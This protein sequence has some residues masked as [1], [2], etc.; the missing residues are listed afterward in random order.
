MELGSRARQRFEQAPRPHSGTSVW[1]AGGRGAGGEGPCHGTKRGLGPQNSSSRSLSLAVTAC[2]QTQLLGDCL[3]DAPTARE[4]AQDSCCWGRLGG[5][6]RPFPEAYVRSGE[7]SGAVLLVSLVWAGGMGRISRRTV[8][9]F[10]RN[11]VENMVTVIKSEHLGSTYCMP[12]TVPGA[13]SVRTQCILKTA[14]GNPVVLIQRQDS[15]SRRCSSVTPSVQLGRRGVGAARDPGPKPTPRPRRGGRG[16]GGQ[17]AIRRLA[18]WVEVAG[19]RLVDSLGL[20]AQSGLDTSVRAVG[21]ETGLSRLDQ[22]WCEALGRTGGKAGPGVL[23]ATHPEGSQGGP[24]LRREGEGA[25]AS[26]P[27]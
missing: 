10:F 16:G 25:L 14:P 20:G 15:E 4:G 21:E 1:G 12:G 3:G 18:I 23:C 24:C 7:V 26:G 27:P 5:A 13:F 6:W 8:R 11:W 17:R 9:L 22:H 19:R 2:V